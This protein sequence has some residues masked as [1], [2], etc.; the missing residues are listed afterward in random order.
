[1]IVHFFLFT[2]I[3]VFQCKPVKAIWDRSIT[4]ECI[5][6][7]AV[8]YTGGALAIFEDLFI[9]VLPLPELWSLQLDK[10]KRLVLVSMFSIGLL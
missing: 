5:N 1:M 8:G 2:F 4:G 6:I 9:L 7:T 3:L 10:K